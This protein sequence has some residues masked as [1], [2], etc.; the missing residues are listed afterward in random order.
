MSNNPV[1]AADCA[2]EVF[3]GWVT[4]MDPVNLPA[5]VSPNCPENQF[6]PGSAFTRAAFKKIFDP[7]LAPN[8]TITYGKSFVAPTGVIYNLY[9]ASNGNLYLENLTI[10]PETATI[11]FTTFPG[12]FCRSVTAFNREYLALS[13]G[14]HGTDAPMQF[15]GTNF[16]RVTESGPGAPPI[17][18]SVALPPA[19]MV[20]S[21]NTLTRNNN[22]VT[23]ATAT[24]HNLKVGY[25]VQISNVPDS[26]ATSVV[27]SMNSGVEST[28]G[29]DWSFN[30]GQYRSNFNPGTSP[31]NAFVAEG[32]GFTIPSTAT[33]L[34]VQVSFGI[35]SQSTTTGT[36]NEVALWYAGS[37][38][39]TG[40]TPGT[41]INTTITRHSYGSAGDLW[42][43]SLTP[44]IVNSPSFGFAVSCA[45]DS[46][47]VF[48][49]FPF[50]VQV[51]YTLSG[52]GTFAEI[53]SIVINNEVNS[54]LA[55]VTTTEPH[56][57]APN[58]FVSI[59]GV[60]PALVSD[61]TAAEWVA[62]TTT[63]T[64]TVTHNLV[65]GSVIQVASV[66]TATGSTTFSFN[67]TFTILTVPSP[68]QVTY[69]QVPITAT[70]PDIIDAT[71]ATGNIT[72]AWP[73]PDNTPTPTYFEV[74][75]CPTPTTFYV[76]VTYSDGAWTTGT[77]GF[78]WEGIFYVTTV[79][80]AND[81][82]Y[83]QP[84][85]NGA[86]TAVGTVTPFGQ[87]APGIH[88][89]RQ[90]FLTRQGNLTR[91]SPW[92]QFTANGG[93]YLQLDDIAI[94]PPNI[95]SRVLE[96]T[97]ALGSQFFYL[98]VPPISQ[99]M[100]VGTATQI[101]DNTTTSILLDF[102][103]I[104]LFAG[105]STSKP[106]NNTAAQITLDGA[107][108]FASFETYLLAWGQ[109]NVVTNLLNMDLAGGTQPTGPEPFV[110]TGWTST[111][112]GGFAYTLI[113]SRVG[114]ELQVNAPGVVGAPISFSQGA[115]QD[116]YGAPILFQN[117][118]YSYRAWI[119]SVLGNESL[120]ATISSVSAGFSTSAVITALTTGPLGAYY[121]VQFDQKTPTPIPPDMLFT[122]SALLPVDGGSISWSQTNVIYTD[123]P[124]TDSIIN[125]SYSENPEAFD[126][127]TGQQGPAYDP[128]QIV[129]FATLSDIP[130]A[131]TRDPS[132]RL[133][134]I[135]ATGTTLPAGWQWN[136]KAAN[137]GALSA[138]TLTKSQADDNSSSGGEEW[139]A[140]ASE[141][142]ARIF[143]GNQPWK[144]SQEIQPNWNEAGSTVG[145]NLQ[146]A[147]T[148]W[149]LNDPVAR[150]LYFGL[151]LGSATAP[152]AIYQMS[153]R[154]LD[155]AEQI[156]FSPPYRVAFSG[157][158]IATDNT[159]KWSP[160]YRTMNGAARMYRESGEL[161]P[162]FFVG[163][164]IT[165][166]VGGFGNVYYLD[167]DFFTDDDFGQI[168]SYY[169]TCAL[170]TREMEM[171]F[172]LGSGLKLH[173]FF[174][175][176]ISAIGNITITMYVNNLQNPWPLT[177]VRQPGLNPNFDLEWGGGNCSK[178]QRY[179]FKVQPSP[180]TGSDTYFNVNRLVPWFK[181]AK[182]TSRG[183]AH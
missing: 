29:G 78:A 14:F 31:L 105:L 25:Q 22:Y 140:W 97:G 63:L 28:P 92:V 129:D 60:E 87:A 147:F 12:T 135:S 62:G 137:C 115:Y 123:T 88:L 144:I 119:S 183:S 51:F 111:A 39:G 21:G 82:I 32:M 182:T 128:R 46:I 38:E 101:N 1:N 16:D 98:P 154:E 15:D 54:G 53:A 55:L 34:G 132:G 73:I 112:T 6:V 10:A 50:T 163:N 19:Q 158:L 37:I 93:Q 94:G 59:V 161:T 79:I 169:T 5:G 30:S 104:S 26:N 110:P 136:E 96:F 180:I 134:E 145:V 131:L 122:M 64:T 48:L 125:T 71:A 142:G 146:A 13:D 33:I 151:P 164:G 3:G 172:Q 57:L 47:R 118:Q 120:T 76:Q 69:L 41:A 56:G 72:V 86:T 113:P 124:Y 130:Y 84:G 24:P 103:D 174:T 67:G 90:S 61:I 11:L 159:R 75:S 155:T 152:S 27:Q 168:Q 148:A 81:F 156:A 68:N 108:G 143:G 157:K 170:P 176:F 102:A 95:Q 89:C 162:I 40:K 150:T 18:T 8:A 83:Y 91:P 139:F 106:G 85:P 77:V 100:I 4:E 52:S 44:S 178:G 23:A 99:G 126:G 167:P 45:C 17:V 36:V 43:A 42:S 181:K 127:V 173:Q 160:W 165:P 20:S 65:P 66:T 149:T 177:C 138:F 7:P 117:T 70:D 35:N 166:G 153:Y 2:L 109:R 116:K 121:Q 171:Q 9:L 74:L 49:N 80:D 114:T 175:A 141:S 133:H 107:L 58:E 179:F